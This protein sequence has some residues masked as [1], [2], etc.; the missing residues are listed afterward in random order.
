MVK[1]FFIFSPL[2]LVGRW[3]QENHLTSIFDRVFRCATIGGRMAKRTDTPNNKM[4]LVI[5][6]SINSHDN[7]CYFECWRSAQKTEKKA[8]KKKEQRS[9]PVF[10]GSFHCRP[11][12]FPM[13]NFLMCD[14]AGR[15]A[16]AG[17]FFLIIS[18]R[19][20]FVIRYYSFFNGK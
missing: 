19:Y 3:R 2:L 12:V 16:I 13:G 11:R 15:L 8:R 20:K 10:I 6:T 1:V 9:N 5:I 14:W 4:P 17:G 18:I 7:A